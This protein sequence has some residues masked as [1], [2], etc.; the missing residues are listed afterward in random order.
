MRL[1]FCECACL[2]PDSMWSVINRALR[3]LFY[4]KASWDFTRHAHNSTC[5][6]FIFNERRCPE[7][8]TGVNCMNKSKFD[9]A[10]SVSTYAVVFTVKSLGSVG[11]RN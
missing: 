11:L 3:D 7:T 5:M 9:L 2:A 10:Y 1:N 8:N 6:H 4:Y